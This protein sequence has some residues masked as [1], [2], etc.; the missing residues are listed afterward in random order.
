MVCIQEVV[1]QGLVFTT[2]YRGIMNRF[3]RVCVWQYIYS[4]LLC[5]VNRVIQV[6]KYETLGG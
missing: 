4:V 2:L 6:C 5:Y 3:R 1:Y